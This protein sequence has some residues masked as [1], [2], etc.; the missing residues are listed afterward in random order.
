MFRS[1]LALLIIS[2]MALGMHAQQLTTKSEDINAMFKITPEKDGDNTSY[3]QKGDNVLVH[4]TGT[5][6]DGRKFDS[7]RDRG[8]PLDFPVGM[9]HVI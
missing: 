5:F 2:L 6:Q 8:Q 7:S 4:Y 3:P 9:G 1:T